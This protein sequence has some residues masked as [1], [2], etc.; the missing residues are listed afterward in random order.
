MEKLG[1]AATVLDD[2]HRNRE[3]MFTMMMCSD[4]IVKWRPTG[5]DGY[6]G[7]QQLATLEP[8]L[9]DDRMI[10][11][12]LAIIDCDD[13]TDYTHPLNPAYNMLGVRNWD[14]EM[15]KPGDRVTILINGQER[16]LWEDKKR[17]GSGEE[18][19]DITR[20]LR[21]IGYHY[22]ACRVAAG[23]TVTC[24]PLAKIYREQL[25]KAC[26]LHEDEEGWECSHPEVD[27]VYVFPNSVVPADHD[28][29]NLVPHEGVRILWEGGA[30]HINSW[31]PIRAPLLDVLRNNPHAKL[32]VFGGPE[33]EGGLVFDWMKTEIRPEQ[34]EG[35]PWVDYAAYKLKRSILDCDINLCPIVD[36]PFTRC[37]SAIRWYEGSLGPRPEA[38]LAA[39]VGPYKEIVDGQTGMLYDTPQEFAE[40][41]DLLINNPGLRKTVAFGAQEWILANRDAA[42]TVPG[43]RDF[44]MKLLSKQRQ[45]ALM[46]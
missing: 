43:L 11:P 10:F 19:F 12:P 2:G 30:S 18:V 23:I 46:L 29:P 39:N 31:L 14:G 40:K 15:L 35:H 37:K 20:N 36:E 9:R 44:Y 32:V 5:R 34:L 45:K 1:M 21:E 22:D 24:E 7:L 17:I 6:E 3:R 28:F 25:C 38:A 26:T 33:T 27:N 41:L 42:I 13:A 16:V 4:I 8:Q